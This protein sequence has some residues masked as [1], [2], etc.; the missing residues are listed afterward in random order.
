MKKIA[1]FGSTG[2]IGRSSL[3]VI[4][5]LKSRFSVFALAAKNNFQLLAEQANQIRPQIIVTHDEPTKT[6]LYQLLNKTM[7]RKFIILTG[8]QGLTE[9]AVHKQVDTLIMAM[10][11]TMGI[12]PLLK[13]I[14]QQKQIALSTKELLVGFGAI[15]MQ[16]AKRYQAQILPIDSELAG[17]HQCL[18][19][20][21]LSEIKRVIITASGGP[22]YHRKDLHNITVK[23][24]LQHP[25]WKMGK[26]IT[27]DS[28]TL[29]NK[30]LEVIETARLFSLPQEKI[31]VLIHPQ[32]VIHAMIELNDNSVLAQLAQP[33]M[34]ACI[35]YAL[36]YPKRLPT[37]IKPLDLTTYQKLEFYRP[38]P[39]RFPAL[40]LAYQSLQTGGIAPCVYNT[41]NEIAVSKFLA[42]K[43]DFNIIPSIIR[44][45]LEHMPKIKN[46]KLTDLLK[47][48]KIARAFAQ[49]IK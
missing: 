36:T 28:A 27:I 21:H 44:K 38:D 34:R 41:A 4:G 24:A 5:H 22:F 30:G 47:Y 12:I 37:L 46:P 13:A 29:A 39:H 18:D 8:E 6:R 7:R 49:Q 33:D 14:K 20:R 11:G 19:N 31:S 35:Q 10:S 1:V 3:Q 45:T 40:K 25:V 15:I 48:E 2:S 26:K 17:L 32:S 23:D 9:I 16:Q 42:K 43:I